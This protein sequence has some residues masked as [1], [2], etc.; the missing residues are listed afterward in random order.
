M[1]F[2]T[3][4]VLDHFALGDPRIRIDGI[5]ETYILT[6]KLLGKELLTSNL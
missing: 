5:P 1:P 2:V 3:S 6:D 4:S